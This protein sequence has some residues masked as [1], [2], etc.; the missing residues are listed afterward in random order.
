MAT[1]L[2]Q[3]LA[4]IKEFEGAVPWMYLDTVGKVT[5][6]VGLMLTNEAAAYALP[7]LANGEPATVEAIGR[8]FLRVSA[9]KKGLGSKSYCNPQGLRLSDETI[10]AKLRDTL[11]GF[12][13]YL[14]MHLHGYDALRDA[15][16]L[17]LLDMVY[18]LGPGRLFAEYS[19]LIAAVERG[20]W[21]TAAQASAR[22]GPSAARNLWVKE[23]FLLAAARVDLKA[24]AES[25]GGSVLVGLISGLAATAAA[26]ILFGELDRLARR[27]RQRGNR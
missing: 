14:R 24:E 7:F 9:M 2:E 17:A 8:E 15:A 12:E 10:D 6:G 22:R 27:I 16:K 21:K 20:D 13:S 1:Y 4:K 18:N 3:S 25:P 5:V 19:R 23:Q 26:A 11:Q